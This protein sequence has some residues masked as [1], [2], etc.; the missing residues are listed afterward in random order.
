MAWRGAPPTRRYITQAR[1][2][3]AKAELEELEREQMKELREAKKDQLRRQKADEIAAMR[4]ALSP[5]AGPLLIEDTD[6]LMTAVWAEY[7]LGKPSPTL[8]LMARAS[9]ADHYLL[10]TPETPWTDDGV[11][12]AGKQE[13]REWFFNAA[14][15]R[16]DACGA[17]YTVITGADW[18]ARERQAVKVAEGMLN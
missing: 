9:L 6:A 4:A 3:R 5:L 14:K 16:L 1:A 2:A 8:E 13:E 17:P 11:R 18:D 12:Y 7:L 15:K 10:L